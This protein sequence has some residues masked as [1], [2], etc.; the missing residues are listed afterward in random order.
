MALTALLVLSFYY[1][2]TGSLLSSISSTTPLDEGYKPEPMGVILP[3]PS[4]SSVSDFNSA[5]KTRI[6]LVSAMFPLSKS[7]HTPE[8]YERWVTN[9]LQSVTTEIYF[10]T[11]PSFAPIVRRARPSHL[12]III[13]A[14]YTSPFDVPPLKGLEGVY[15]GLHEK[16]RERR[17]HSSELYAV[18]NVKPFLLDSAA[19]T[20]AAS[21][22]TF[23]Y[24]FWND[25]GSFRGQQKYE[26][27]PDFERV[28]D[29]WRQGTKLTGTKS[30]DLVFFPLYG[31]PGSSMRD[32]KEDMGPVDYEVSEGYHFAQSQNFQSITPVHPY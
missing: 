19:K 28:E 17:I 13:D 18:W 1:S 7:K 12:P 11:T 15:A 10:F 26:S 23:D 22:R 21:G 20:L 9:F 5:N 8:D 6:L 3:K 25:A 14:N 24:V 4:V 30:D 32:W 2:A 27:W 29:I 31:L 16:D